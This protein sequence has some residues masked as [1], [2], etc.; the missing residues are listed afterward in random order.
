M[1]K[2][3]LGGVS[4]V[5]THIRFVIVLVLVFLLQTNVCFLWAVDIKPREIISLQKLIELALDYNLKNKADSKYLAPAKITFL[6]KKYFYQIETQMEQ[7]NTAKEVRGHFQK[8]VEKTKEIFDSGEEGVSQADL[9]KLKLGLSN[10]L[11]NI[12]DLEHG[13][14][15]GKLNLGKLINQELKD[16][17]DIIFTDPIPI[18][19]PYT[20]FDDFLKARN[21]N[22]QSKKITGKSGVA[23][24]E[25]HRAQSIKLTE[26]NRLLLYKAFLE[27]TSSKDK[28]LLSKQNRKITRALLIS[29]VANFD[30]GIGDS[31]ELFEALMIYTRI[32]SSY[33]DSIHT[34]NI[35]A[36]ELE[37][38]TD[39][40]YTKN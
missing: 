7:L 12:I 40:F 19:F 37:K 36:A 25:T 32:F 31:Q 4:V 15:I 20:S 9:T 28:L 39:S 21:L 34:L 2:I 3:F 17:N 38:L 8:A 23:S 13:L 27:V 18:D 1:R 30:F 10:T 24:N 16:D 6:V 35:A 5:S 29:E 11:N 33:L 14:E 22:L 26:E